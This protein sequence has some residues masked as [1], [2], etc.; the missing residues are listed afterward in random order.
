M[1]VT[2]A[3]SHERP[4]HSSRITSGTRQH[5]VNGPG[6]TMTLIPSGWPFK[7]VLSVSGPATSATP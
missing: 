6:A 3:T 7:R 2:T 5:T 1:A 4:A